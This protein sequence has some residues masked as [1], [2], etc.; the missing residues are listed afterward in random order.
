MRSLAI[1]AVLSAGLTFAQ[2]QRAP[3]PT[4]YPWWENNI[5]RN[6]LDLSDAQMKQLN[7]IQQA[8]VGT[9]KDL[10]EATTKAENNLNE[11]YNEDKIDEIKATV[12]VDQYVNARDN[13]T[14]VLAELSLKMRAVLTIEQWQQLEDLQAGRAGRGGRGRG[15]GGQPNGSGPPSGVTSNKVAPPISQPK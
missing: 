10:R 2:P 14:R 6:R 1:L 13:Q 7:A 9:L 5:V 12:A 15:R 3:G 4:Q 8:Y 11:I